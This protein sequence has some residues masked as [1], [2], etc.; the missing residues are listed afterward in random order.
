[1]SENSIT[2]K[3]LDTLREG[4][5]AKE[6][7]ASKNFPKGEVEENDNFLRRSMALMEEAVD[8]KKVLTEDSDGDSGSFVISKS[9]PQFGDIVSSQKE[10]IKKTINDN[11]E[12]KENALKYYPDENDM[13]LDASIPSLN[14]SFRFRYNDTST[15]CYVWC[16]QTVLD[17]ENTR[18]IGKI[19]DAYVNWRNSITAED[20]LMAKLKQAAT[21]DD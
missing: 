13:T 18:T 16:N 19:R 4:R 10:M 6:I 3:M 17:D 15:G 21:K 5:Y 20:D 1:M 14:L 2:K 11:V 12:F 7:S 9:T 8:K